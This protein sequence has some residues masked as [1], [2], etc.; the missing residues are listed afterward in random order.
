MAKYI[1]QYLFDGLA[2]KHMITE[3]GNSVEIFDKL[4]EDYAQ[5]YPDENIDALRADV[6]AAAIEARRVVDGLIAARLYESEG[7]AVDDLMEVLEKA[8]SLQK[9]MWRRMVEN[10][11]FAVQPTPIVDRVARS[12]EH[13]RAAQKVLRDRVAP[14]R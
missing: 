12:R 6:A 13:L 11:L 14:A 5:K 4:I 10:A 9:P 7:D 8:A 3:R 1:P 2:V